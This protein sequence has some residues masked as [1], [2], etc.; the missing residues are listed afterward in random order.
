MDGLSDA[1]VTKVWVGVEYSNKKNCD[2]SDKGCWKWMPGNTS[3][4]PDVLAWDSDLFPPSSPS[5]HVVMDVDY[6]VLNFDPDTNSYR[7]MCMR[8]RTSCEE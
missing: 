8:K 1:L 6:K 4:N 7:Y 5:T 2:P 3:V